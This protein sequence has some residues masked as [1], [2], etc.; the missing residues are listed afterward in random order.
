[1]KDKQRLNFLERMGR[2]MREQEE[3]KKKIDEN[4]WRLSSLERLDYMNNM[5]RINKYYM[6][7]PCP[8]LI[9]IFFRLF[10]YSAGFFLVFYIFS[11]N[12]LFIDFGYIFFMPLIAFAPFLALFE[13]LRFYLMNS[14]MSKDKLKVRRAFGLEK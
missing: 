7:Y 9:R 1:M 4:Y 8:S 10:F 13:L 5:E 2:N 14:L 11:G 12:N 6:N 3:K